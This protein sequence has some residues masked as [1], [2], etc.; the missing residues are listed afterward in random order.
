MSPLIFSPNEISGYDLFLIIGVE[1]NKEISRFATSSP[2]IF[3]N[4]VIVG[5]IVYNLNEIEIFND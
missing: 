3:E 4:K 1:N 5:I 2:C